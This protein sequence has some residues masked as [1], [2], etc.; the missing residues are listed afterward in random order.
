MSVRYEG[1][2]NTPAHCAAAKEFLSGITHDGH[3]MD[4]K[5]GHDKQLYR[6]SFSDMPRNSLCLMPWERLRPKKELIRFCS[7]PNA[8]G[9]K[10][11]SDISQEE[12]NSSF[13]FV[14]RNRTIVGM[15][16]MLPYNV[17]EEPKARVQIFR[18]GIIEEDGDGG[19][20]TARTVSYAHIM[21]EAE[22][23]LPYDPYC[24]DNPEE[25]SMHKTDI[26]LPCMIISFL[27]FKTPESL[28][29]DGNEQFKEKWP[30]IEITLSKIRSIKRD[31]LK[32]ANSVRL[33]VYVLC[34]AYVYFETLAFSLY[35]NKANR[36]IV[37]GACLMIACKFLH[38]KIALLEVLAEVLRVSTEEIISAEFPVLVALKFSLHFPQAVIDPHYHRL[39]GSNKQ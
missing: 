13:V 31:L 30:E 4:R 36:K 1:L 7:F 15:F 38:V 27:E 23:S 33:P 39:I 11:T 28:K 37:A 19:D 6:R 22:E 3:S 32:V 5:T 8:R 20:R 16:S 34:F 2:A 9:I 25:K 10:L 24:L 14:T 17:A 18:G 35:I 12:S 21:D 26:N 29:R